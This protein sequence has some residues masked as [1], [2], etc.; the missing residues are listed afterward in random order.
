M[1]RMSYNGSFGVFLACVVGVSSWSA[2]L[3]ADAPAPAPANDAALSL[4]EPAPLIPGAKVVVLWP[5]GSPALH[6]MPGS[7]KPEQFN[8]S[9]SSPAKVQS[10]V[11]IHNPSIEVH[12]A[13]ADKA[14]G[15]AVIVI[16]G[17][18]NKTCNVGNE[19]V[20]IADW[21]NGLGVHAFIERYR[22][23]PYD[24]TVDAFADTQRSI[25]MV[26]ADAR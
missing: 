21:L 25:R 3:A 13:P 15:M 1:M 11:N 7:D 12:L 23:K 18:G 10:V 5:K 24:S 26:R 6:A 4:A 8:L 2:A 17:G 20:D 14:N 16:A 19:G 22:L 9:K